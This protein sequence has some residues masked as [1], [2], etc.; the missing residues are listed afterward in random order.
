MTLT[1][2]DELSKLSRTALETKVLSLHA[3]TVT[4]AARIEHLESGYSAICIFEVE[5]QQELHDF[6]LE[7]VKQNYA[8][9]I[10][11]SA[12]TSGGGALR[13]R[14]AAASAPGGNGD[15]DGDDSHRQETR[16]DATEASHGRGA[17]ISTRYT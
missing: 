17:R 11:R 7:Q 13:Q 15:G 10:P 16:G 1:A 3:L 4:Q 5:R 9:S 6:E 14:L 12:T 8:K 2:D